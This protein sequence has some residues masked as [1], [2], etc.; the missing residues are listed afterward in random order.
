MKLKYYQPIIAV[1]ILSF[2]LASCVKEIEYNGEKSKSFLV[3]N[4]I[5]DND[6]TFRIYMEKSVFFLDANNGNNALSDAQIT[7]RNKTTGTSESL[8]SGTDGMYN[9][10]MVAQEGHVYEVEASYPNYEGISATTSIPSTV[11]L[12][13]VDTV[14]LPGASSDENRLKA[15]LTWNDPTEKNYYVVACKWITPFSGEK[16]NLSSKDIAITNV[17]SDIVDGTK[18]ATLFALDDVTFN[19]SQK[20][21]DIEFFRPPSNSIDQFDFYLISCTED[22][23]KYLLSAENSL[24][25]G[26][27][28]FTEP[29]KVK[30]N[31][32]NGLGIF[33]G[34]N[35]YVVV[36]YD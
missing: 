27:D 2:L 34:I 36:K 16:F 8:T 31:I 29:V 4:Q 3:L 28:P 21:L 26:N 11:P 13:S 35:S 18:Y 25:A 17:E 1:S 32:E 7:L 6:S 24:N 23:Y 5:I 15:T 22:A 10:S 19:G 20:S 9:F 14:S 30:T 33:A 12:I